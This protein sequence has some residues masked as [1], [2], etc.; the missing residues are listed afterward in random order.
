[1]FHLEL[2]IFTLVLSPIY[3]DENVSI[4]I[5]QGTL[6]GLKVQ[7]YTNNVTYYTFRSVPYAKAISTRFDVSNK[8]NI[9]LDIFL[10]KLLIYYYESTQKS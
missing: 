2:F 7:T 9:R 1:M 8:Y 6:L 3:G 4:D 5:P 10:E